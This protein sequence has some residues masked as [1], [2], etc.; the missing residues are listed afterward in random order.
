MKILNKP[1]PRITTAAEVT[2]VRT[3]QGIYLLYPVNIA[4]DAERSQEGW[5]A[6][7]P[8][9]TWISRAKSVPWAKFR[10]FKR[11]WETMT[12]AITFI[13]QMD[14]IPF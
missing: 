8:D 2:P 13:H 11:T 9:G 3:G 12:D 6:R 5:A 10:P 1:Y 7:R 14:A 4:V